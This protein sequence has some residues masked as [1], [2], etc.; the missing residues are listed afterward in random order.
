MS[1]T[2]REKLL[3]RLRKFLPEEYV[4]EIASGDL[5]VNQEDGTGL[6]LLA[7]VCQDDRPEAVDILV[8]LG[9]DPWK[10]NELGGRPIHEAIVNGNLGVARKLLESCP[11]VNLADNEDRGTLLHYVA[12][13]QDD[14]IDS[15]ASDLIANGAK[16]DVV[17]AG[18]WTPLLIAS[19]NG[20]RDLVATLLDAGADPAKANGDGQRAID[21]AA[22]HPEVRDLLARARR[23]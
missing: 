5:D 19:A 12:A 7:L 20:K 9:A 22:D 13:V 6:S 4:D 8:A 1:D 10:A 16:V 17:D 14:A 15:L 2:N 11:D 21:L 18:G 3:G 23:S